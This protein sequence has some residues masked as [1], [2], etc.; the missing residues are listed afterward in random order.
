MKPSMQCAAAA[1]KANRILGQLSRAVQWRDKI[2]F[3]KLFMSHV[4]PVLEYAGTVWCPYLVGDRET[5][6]KVQ[7]RM[8]S[9]IPGMRGS[10][11]D[12]LRVLGM[13]TLQRRRERGDMIQTWRILNGKDRVDPAN[14]FIHQGDQVREGATSTRGHR[15]YQALLSRPPAKLEVRREFFSNR[16]VDEYNRLP[17]R[18]KMAS[19][20]N[21]FKARLDEHL[22]TPAPLQL[23]GRR[24]QATPWKSGGRWTSASGLKTIITS[25]I[26]RSM[27]GPLD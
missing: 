4:R 24:G 19:N 23:R 20:M 16:V 6:E 18:V 3:P 27:C 9:M 26:C 17:D 15:G 10:Y 21:M 11:E 7:K 13:T 2:T 1:T 25:I 14:W 12:K 8:V 5:L 22:G